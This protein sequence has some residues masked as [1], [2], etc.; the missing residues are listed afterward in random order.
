MSDETYNTPITLNISQYDVHPPRGA[1]CDLFPSSSQKEAAF[2]LSSSTWQLEFIVVTTIG[3]FALSCILRFAVL[4]PASALLLGPR[5]AS[6]VKRDKFAQSAQEF[7][8]YSA[9][10]V[11]GGRLLATE[12]WAWPSASWWSGNSI[13][14]H[15]SGALSVAA[16]YLLYLS[17]YISNLVFVVF[18]DARRKDFWEMVIHHAVTAL[19]VGLSFEGSFWRV[20]LVIMVLLDIGD[21][22]LHF[23]KMAKYLHE[24]R[25]AGVFLAIANQTFNVFGVAF[26]VTRIVM[27]GY[28]NWSCWTEGYAE[29]VKD[30]KPH[31]IASTITVCNVMVSILYVLQWFWFSLLIKAVVRMSQ[32][33]NVE[34]NRSDSEDESK[35]GR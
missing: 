1:F 8:Q 18:I 14:R 3:F 4:N 11:L 9:F 33:G 29:A 32:T 28:V 19:L 35:K 5:C 21:P 13:G 17:R 16:F 34:D 7:V 26:F 24:A 2:T 6:S 27:Y 10:F 23:A 22:P 25:G 30:G 31:G 12:P 15:D 20:G